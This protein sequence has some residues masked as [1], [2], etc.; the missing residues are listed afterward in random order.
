MSQQPVV[1]SR[2]LGVLERYFAGL[3]LPAPVR[4]AFEL[5]LNAL[6]ALTLGGAVVGAFS[7]LMGGTR[8]AC[9]L[10][11]FSEE[12]SA[13]LVELL[14]TTLHVRLEELAEAGFIKRSH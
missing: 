5:E 7:G 1:P 2:V 8:M 4:A 12:H 14:G 10:G 9:A 11:V 3:C 13:A 6:P